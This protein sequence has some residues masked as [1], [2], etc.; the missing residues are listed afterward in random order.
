MAAIEMNSQV[1]QERQ[2]HNSV[3]VEVEQD[4]ADQE[5][6]DII[7]RK[8]I[9]IS[10]SFDT[11]G[12][13]TVLRGDNKDQPAVVQKPNAIVRPVR[14]DDLSTDNDRTVAAVSTE[15]ISKKDIVQFTKELDS[16]LRRLQ[17]RGDKPQKRSDNVANANS[18]VQMQKR[19]L[20]ITTVPKGVFLQPVKEIPIVRNP[21]KG[22][23][24]FAS[25][26]KV[27]VS[28]LQRDGGGELLNR[29]TRSLR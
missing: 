1:Q 19:P 24:A 12:A 15:V 25:R 4:D 11:T 3:E 14:R 20:F 17:Y 8:L 13:F 22:L 28:H 2:K 23:Y 16:K 5:D 7:I 9:E 27:M 18:A 29:K 21:H 26:P 10:S 6:K